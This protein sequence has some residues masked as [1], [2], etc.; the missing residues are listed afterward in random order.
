MERLLDRLRLY[1]WDGA[2]HRYRV[3]SA[4][5]VTTLDGAVAVA[6]LTPPPDVTPEGLSLW[7]ARKLRGEVFCVP[8]PRGLGSGAH[9]RRLLECHLVEEPGATVEDAKLI[10]SELIN[11]AVVH[12]AGAIRL[13][14]S[15]PPGRLSMEVI[16]DGENATIRMLDPGG[17]GGGR[18]LRI[19]NELAHRRGAREGT[20]HSGPSSAAH[21]HPDS[22]RIVRRSVKSVA[23]LRMRSRPI[24]LMIFRLA[25]SAT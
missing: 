15:R 2:P 1:G 13:R 8:L 4:L 24:A 16:D 12:G 21:H 18:G 10:A 3:R 22:Y 25:S 14:L 6:H 17:D 19:V 7:Q 20:T 11:N 23:L 5:R 9:A